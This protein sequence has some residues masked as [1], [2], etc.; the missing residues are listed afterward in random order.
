MNLIEAVEVMKT[1][2]IVISDENIKYKIEDGYLLM[3]DLASN[4]WLNSRLDILSAVERN[5]TL[6]ETLSNKIFCIR[7]P[8][9]VLYPVKDI[10]S[11]KNL[12]QTIKQIKVA[13]SNLNYHED[14]VDEIIETID[15]H[16]GPKF[17]D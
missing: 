5:F 8:Q 13:L 7:A 12:K 16:L 10:I 11:V 9:D 2:K 6:Y 1:G 4:K 14:C 17:K 15:K 3:H